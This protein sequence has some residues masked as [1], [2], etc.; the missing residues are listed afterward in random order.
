MA[1]W[2]QWVSVESHNL[3]PQSLHWPEC[4]SGP[5]QTACGAGRR[6]NRDRGSSCFAFSS[7][8][9]GWDPYPLGV[10]EIA[11][12]SER[13]T[14]LTGR[15]RESTGV[16]HHPHHLKGQCPPKN[17]KYICLPLIWVCMS[18]R[19]VCL[20]LKIIEPDGTR[21]V[22]LKAPLKMNKYIWKNSPW[23]MIWLIK[24]IH[25]SCLKWIHVGIIFFL[26]NLTEKCLSTHGGTAIWLS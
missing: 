25:K 26:C 15:Q 1:W 2:A 10:S 3:G 20:L 23:I 21:L 8:C 6:S 16:T 19:D 22:F 4:L 24:I 12:G 14:H 5:P 13:N 9:G 7:F 17:H 11:A 18:P